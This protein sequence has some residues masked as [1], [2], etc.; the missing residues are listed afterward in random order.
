MF[1]DE[2]M[3]NLKVHKPDMGSAKNG[4]FDFNGRIMNEYI[5]RNLRVASIE[6]KLV[7][8]CI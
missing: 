7:W 3:R 2:E 1:R 6:E 5:I 4:S 8:A